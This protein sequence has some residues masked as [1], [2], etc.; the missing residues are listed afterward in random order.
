MP[1]PCVE[2]H[3]L[4]PD[5]CRICRWCCD[6]SEIGA[7]HRG[8]WG[9]PEPSAIRFA[10][11]HREIVPGL[12]DPIADRPLDPA[13]DR[14]P[15]DGRVIRRHREAL[16]FLAGADM[17]PPGPRSGAGVLL[18]GGGKYWPGIVVAVK[19]LR[20]TGSTLPVQ[21][22]H[23]GTHEPVRPA[24]LAG[25]GDVQIHD[26]TR[27]NPPPRILRGWDAKTLAILAC[28]WERVFFHDA[29]AYCLIDP[30]RFLDRLSA[31]APFLFWEDHP[32]AENAVHWSV[33]GLANTPIPPVQGGQFAIHVRHFW[34]DL[35]LAH[36]LNQH[37]D[38]SYAHQFGDQDSW[39]VALTFSK[40][41]HVRLGPAPWDEVAFV[42]SVDDIPAVVHRCAAKMLFPE[43]V[44]E[45]DRHANRRLDRLPGEERAWQH[46]DALA[47]ARPAADV[48]ARVYANSLWGPGQC[49]G[50]GSIPEQAQPYLDLIN[51]LAKISGWRRVV[52]LGCGDG[53]VAS[54][55]AV[56][57][58]V[59][60][61]CHAFHIDRLKRQTPARQW[62]HLDIDR[63]R[64]QLPAGD[65][66][67]LKDVLHHWPTP[68]VRDWL[69]WAKSC[70]KWRWLICT[71][72]RQQ[73]QDDDDCPLGGY[74]PLSPA[75]EPLRSLGLEPLAD[76]LYKSVLVLPVGDDRKLT[77]DN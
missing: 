76:Y 1:R 59:G 21:I 12:R 57:D 26:F 27:I 74:R 19:M 69:A 20:D 6:D 65:V 70:G 50:A 72:D 24:D 2:D 29:D 36:W 16:R 43:D 22:W 67:L 4:R 34:R 30:V 18:I 28:G 8:Q 38:F 37:A 3:P 48:F 9:E 61:D 44:A 10:P 75:L 5:S 73:A 63:Q 56:P 55:L 66:A 49:S 15:H 35:V 54:R 14:W 7:F 52:D 62:L 60:V 42:C 45:G 46:F 11:A 40:S 33:W 51:C 58:V 23:R 25:L 77:I 64:D 31:R 68:L 47:S 53:Y 32:G 39:R 71:Q 17:P 13:S 41:P